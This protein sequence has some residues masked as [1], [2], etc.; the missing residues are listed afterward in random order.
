MK[1]QYQCFVR[2]SKMMNYTLKK[3][4]I[5]HNQNLKYVFLISYILAKWIS[6]VLIIFYYHFT[7]GEKPN[8]SL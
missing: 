8:E 3:G 5:A 7:M 6:E 1:L 2:P 4:K